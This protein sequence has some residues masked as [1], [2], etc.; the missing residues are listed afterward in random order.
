MGWDV[1]IDSVGRKLTSGIFVLRFLANNTTTHSVTDDG[2]FWAILPA[3]FLRRG[4][5]GCL[6]K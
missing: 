6:R 4:I 2:V 3:F 5:L 1:R